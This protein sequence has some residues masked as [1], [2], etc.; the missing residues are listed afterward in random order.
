MKKKILIVDDEEFMLTTMSY[1]LKDKGYLVKCAKDG[2]NA[3]DQ[4]KETQIK[5]DF[6]DLIVTDIKMPN[7]DGLELIEK[8]NNENIKI[9]VITMTGYHDSKTML[10]VV[11]KGCSAYLIKPVKM[12]KLL[13][14][15]NN[16][17][18]N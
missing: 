8:L 16:N 6:F 11:K 1:L 7:V 18:M 13:E 14:E 10:E 9:P 5:G 4:I 17:I 2:Q 15:I 12:E 3:Y